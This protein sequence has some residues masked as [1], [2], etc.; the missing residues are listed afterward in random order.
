MYLDLDKTIS[1]LKKVNI[2]EQK[3]ITELIVQTNNLDNWDFLDECLIKL[4]EEN[5]KMESLISQLNN[6]T[7]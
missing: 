6:L 1:V 5:K 2:E 3:Y 4:N 7:K